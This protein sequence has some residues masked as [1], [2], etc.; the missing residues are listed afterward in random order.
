MIQKQALT[1]TGALRA[2]PKP[3]VAACHTAYKYCTRLAALQAAAC[4]YHHV[5]QCVFTLRKFSD[6]L[7]CSRADRQRTLRELEY[8]RTLFREG[9]KWVIRH[10][11]GDYKTGRSYGERPPMA[12]AP[13]VYP[14]VQG[15][16]YKIWN[17]NPGN[18]AYGP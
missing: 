13:H 16:L 18:P 8:G 15:I 6:E 11:A 17:I 12:I 10:Q 9:D 7:A 14:E 4:N 5:P 1:G 3:V 2:Q